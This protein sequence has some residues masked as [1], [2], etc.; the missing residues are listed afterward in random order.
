MLDEGLWLVLADMHVPFHEPKPIESTVSYG[1]KNKV[2]GILIAGDFQD[3]MSI[4]YWPQTRKRDYDAELVMVIDMLDFLRYEFPKAKIVYKMGNHEY[5]LPA[6]YYKNV[7]ELAGIP[8]AAMDAVLDLEGRGIETVEYTQLTM[9]GKLPIY[10]G[11]EF[12]ICST[13]SPARGL[14]L[15]TATYGA[16]A[17]FH[18]TS[19]HPGKNVF[20]ELLTTHSFGC[21][22]DLHPDWNPWGNQWN[23]GT[24]LI[25][26]E[27]NGFF[28]IENKRILSNGKIV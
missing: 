17:H 19:M 28:E 9:A 1:Q 2:T 23:W 11:H 20:D 13:I 18:Q 7:P 15:K 8:L 16:C 21:L 26:V 25:N 4:S 3:C 27:K 14:F 6:K 12:K 24:A 5:R 10:H 22:C